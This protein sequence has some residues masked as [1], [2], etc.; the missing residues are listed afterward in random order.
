MP[1]RRCKRCEAGRAEQAKHPVDLLRFGLIHV[2]NL[3]MQGLGRKR[4]DWKAC[5]LAVIAL[6]GS[7]CATLGDGEARGEAISLTLEASETTVPLSAGT[8]QASADDAE[9]STTTATGSS[10]STTGVEGLPEAEPPA[11][12]DPPPEPVVGVDQALDRRF[13]RVVDVPLSD[14]LNVRSGPGIGEGVVEELSPGEPVLTSGATATL[15]TGTI[16]YELL[17]S[18]TSAPLGWAHGGFLALVD[19]PVVTD[20][21]GLP[22]ASS[23]SQ[24]GPGNGAVAVPQSV[25][26]GCNA[27]Q[28]RIAWLAGGGPTG[29]GPSNVLLGTEPPSGSWD[30]T[31]SNTVWSAGASTIHFAIEPGQAVLVTLP[32]NGTYHVMAIGPGNSEPMV[33]P[34]TGLPTVN[35]QGRVDS[36]NHHTIDVVAANGC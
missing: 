34:G 11:E 31:L 30:G 26:P 14:T 20:L 18:S 12:A 21:A 29:A 27:A 24:G 6:V 7:G 4:A 1:T 35:G 36:A 9:T 2:E 28:Y 10:S 33:D 15:P 25:V 13:H 17:D 5:A 19:A 3:Q 16:W 23:G 8:A 32:T 22:V